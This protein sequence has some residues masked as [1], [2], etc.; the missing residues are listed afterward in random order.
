[1]ASTMTVMRGRLAADP[2]FFPAHTGQDGDQK[3]AYAEVPVY[4]SRRVQDSDGQ[5]GE[6]PRGPEKAKAK[7][8]GRDAELLNAAG[9][10][11]GDP[12]VVTGSQGEP[13]SFITKEGQAD[14]IQVINGDTLN[15]DSF[16]ITAKKVAEEKTEAAPSAAQVS[17]AEAQWNADAAQ[18]SA[19]GFAH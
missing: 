12:V 6:D 14:S 11:K 7:F 5:W 1:M 16:R 4:R 19:K 15:L 3:Q 8:F 13:E 9:F 18:A 10:H 17:S 2:R